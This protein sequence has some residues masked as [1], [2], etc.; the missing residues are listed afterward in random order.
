[1]CGASGVIA[2]VTRACCPCD[3]SCCLTVDREKL[4]G[5]FSQIN[6][7]ILIKFHV[8]LGK[9]MLGY[10]KLLKEGLGT[11]A[12]S[13]DAVC[14]WVNAIKNG[15]KETDDTLAVQPQYWQP[16]NTM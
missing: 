3:I 10:Y 6:V 16:V 7:T 2:A 14:Q 12:P 1:M 13:Y 8:F 4:Q 5:S 9:S 11:H 15:Q